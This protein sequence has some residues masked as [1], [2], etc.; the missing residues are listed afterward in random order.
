MG[1]SENYKKLTEKLN[2]VDHLSQTLG[3]LDWDGAVNL[4]EKSADQ[5]AKQTAALAKIVHQEAT[6]PEI[7]DLIRSLEK[8]TDLNHKE[9]ALIREAR[10]DYDL[11]AKL[12]DDFVAKK[13]EAES[14]GF[15]TW[16]K[17]REAQDFEMFAPKLEH[18]IELSL[19]EAAF[20]GQAESPYD[21]FIDR[22]D[23][24][25]DSATIEKL[26]SELKTELVPIVREI[27]SSPV[28]PDVSFLNGFSIEKQKELVH[29]VAEKLGFDFGYGRLDTSVHPFCA[30]NGADTRMTTR[31]HEDNPLDS[32]F[33]TIHETGHALY[34][35]GLPK[36]HLGNPLGKAVGMGIHESQSRMWENQVSRSSHFWKYWE[37]RLREKFPQ[38]TKPISSEQLYLA[39]NAVKAIPI[40]VDSDEVTYNLHIILRFELEKKLFSGKLKVKELP[41]AWNALMKELL[42]LT[43]KNYKEG[44]MQDVHWSC[45]GFGYFPSYCLGNMIAS[46]LWYKALEVL[47]GLTDEFAQGK[48]STLLNWLRENI[49]S[50]G[51]QFGTQE[52]VKQVTGEPVS[53]KALIRYLKERYLPLYK[54]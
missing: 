27:E 42:G 24:G 39:I 43:P 8:E 13:K 9:K 37:P 52:L 35:Q 38:A 20:Q 51:R 17:A 11:A 45:G 4:P 41:D 32:F 46:Q 23:P 14:V 40:R 36:E 50:K 25:M 16:L 49:H 26:F 21:Y 19:E 6:S 5:R 12:P 48:Y 34:E 53:P 2:H 7:D 15:H 54:H 18:L 28:K 31:F 30:G 29:E 1:K 10:R 22:H 3:L 44:V 33:S 47:P